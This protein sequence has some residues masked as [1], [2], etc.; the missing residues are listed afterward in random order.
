M[1]SSDIEAAF[2]HKLRDMVLGIPS[3]ELTF[4]SESNKI[5]GIFSPRNLGDALLAWDYAKRNR[6]SVITPDY[7]KNVHFLL[8]RNLNPLVAGRYRTGP[9]FYEERETCFPKLIPNFV[10]EWCCGFNEQKDFKVEIKEEYERFLRI[11][12]FVDGNGRMARVLMNIQN[13][14]SGFS[15]ILFVDEETVVDVDNPSRWFG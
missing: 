10:E 1:E 12:P 11:H 14:N 4:L 2:N 3:W 15:P 6:F 9:C 7:V 8:M 13:L 5:R